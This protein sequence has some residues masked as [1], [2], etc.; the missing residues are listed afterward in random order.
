MNIKIVAATL[1]IVSVS[2]SCKP[3]TADNLEEMARRS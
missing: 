2:I 1:L 3:K